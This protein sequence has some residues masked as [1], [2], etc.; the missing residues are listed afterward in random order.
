MKWKTKEHYIKWYYRFSLLPKKCI[1]NTNFWLEKYLVKKEM[2][3]MISPRITKK[4]FC[5]DCEFRMKK[6]KI[7]KLARRIKEEEQWITNP[8]VAQQMAGNLSSTMT[9]ISPANYV[10]FSNTN[11]SSV[12]SVPPS[13]III[14]GNIK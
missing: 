13:N 14:T 2:N 4:Y 5:S 10:T 6:D 9:Y 7:K 11:S 12:T 8:F 1:C 3:T